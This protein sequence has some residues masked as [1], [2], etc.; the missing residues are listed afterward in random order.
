MFTCFMCQKK[1]REFS[2]LFKHLKFQHALYPSTS[3]RLKCGEQGCQRSFCSYSGFRRHLISYKHVESQTTILC[4]AQ[5]Q[6][7]VDNDEPS[8]SS[9][10]S[11][12]Q[13]APV[14]PQDFLKDMC[15]SVIAQLQ[16]S[17]IP[18]TTVQTI[19]NS[20]EEVVNDVQSQAQ[21][22]VLKN[23]CFSGV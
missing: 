17:G 20:M 8:A 14:L 1:H 23:V 9:S 13:T 6:S 11:I 4:A 10:T 16:A 19:V 3:L 22:A 5:R 2:F 18:E 12:S 7:D 21:E 15:R